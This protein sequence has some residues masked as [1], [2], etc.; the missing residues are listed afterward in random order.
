[1]VMIMEDTRLT[2]AGFFRL[3]LTQCVSFLFF[4]SFRLYSR[5]PL[6][7]LAVSLFIN[8][9]ENE[10]IRLVLLSLKIHLGFP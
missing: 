1:M 2:F 4:S 5:Y 3:F 7:L 6:H 10:N 8:S 9:F